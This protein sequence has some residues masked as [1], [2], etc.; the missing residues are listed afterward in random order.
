M[1]GNPMDEARRW[2][3]VEELFHQAAARPAAEVGAFL[4][5]ACAGDEDLKRR[6]LTLLQAA[7]EQGPKEEDRERRRSSAVSVRPA[8]EPEDGQQDG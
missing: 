8:K 3:R 1:S 7:Q 6:V 4:E 5:R 2:A